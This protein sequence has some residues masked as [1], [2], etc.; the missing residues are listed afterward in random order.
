MDPYNKKYGLMCHPLEGET[1]VEDILCEPHNLSG[2]QK[3]DRE[4]LMEA[5]NNFVDTNALVTRCCWKASI[6]ELEG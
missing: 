1:L 4:K 6:G 3:E 2:S 5:M